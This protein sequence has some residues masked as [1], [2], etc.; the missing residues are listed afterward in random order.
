M[1]R[2]KL[3]A[4]RQSE[5]AHRVACVECGKEKSGTK[6][7][8]LGHKGYR[9]KKEKKNQKKLGKFADGSPVT[10]STS[11]SCLKCDAESSLF[12]GFSGSRSW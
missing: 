6:K 2:N 4:A 10:R 8:S 11:D 9:T 12:A 7:A 1:D 5:N 3:A